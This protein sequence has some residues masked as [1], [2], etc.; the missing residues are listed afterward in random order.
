MRVKSGVKGAPAPEGPAVI[1]AL[2]VAGRP[3]L[4]AD[5]KVALAAEIVAAYVRVR[6]LLARRD[7]RS[8]VQLLRR[9]RA[10]AHPTEAAFVS[11]GRRLGRRVERMLGFL[12]LDARCLVRSCVLIALLARRGIGATL[13]IGVRT[14][15][16]FEAHAWVECAGVP[17]LDPGAWRHTRIME[18]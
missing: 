4:P 16:K 1:T 17:L 18:Y 8:A 6:W 13:V 10:F 11:E 15:P 9:D 2:D 7:V 14:L 12:P 5:R 3:G